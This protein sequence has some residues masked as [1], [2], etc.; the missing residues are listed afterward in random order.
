MSL[1]PLFPILFA[2]NNVTGCH[3]LRFLMLSFK[4]VLLLS[5]F[6]FIRRFFSSSPFSAIAVVPSAYLRL[7][8]FLPAIVNPACD[9]CSPG[10][11]MMHSAC[12]LNKQGD[13]IQPY[14]TPFLIWNQSVI[15]YPVLTV[16]S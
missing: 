8:I 2:M 11:H 9:S 4:P 1:F 14:G 5:S 7:L 12:N 10:F 13:S 6:T 16:A 15:L 3:D